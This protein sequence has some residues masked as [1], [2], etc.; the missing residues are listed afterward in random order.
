MKELY[1]VTSWAWAWR[2]GLGR[3]AVEAEV[4]A[5]LVWLVAGPAVVAAEVVA[6][7]VDDGPRREACREGMLL[8]GE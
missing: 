1:A 2:R 8:V 7:G 6:P 3:V 5:G 4:D